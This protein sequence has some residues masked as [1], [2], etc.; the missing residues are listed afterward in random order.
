VSETGRQR[1]SRL[2]DELRALDAQLRNAGICYAMIGGIAVNMHGFIRATRDLDVML[3]AED[4][5]AMHRLL[6]DMGYEPIDRRP[7]IASYVRG[8]MRVDVL[9]A[10]RPISRGLLE[11]RRETDFHGMKVPAISLEGLIGLKVQAFSDDPQRR[12][13][14]L[15]D[16]I[17]L[18]KINRDHLD[19]DEIRSYFRLFEREALLDDILRAI[20]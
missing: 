1:G 11:A 20:G 10:H 16:M 5:E 4:A 13:R 18:M 15:T 3:L 6:S 7:D 9:F 12:L 2:L 8:T 19:L 14:D 17:E